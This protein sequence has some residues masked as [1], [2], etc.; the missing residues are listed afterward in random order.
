MENVCSSVKRSRKK[1]WRGGLT[2]KKFFGEEL[3]QEERE[4]RR[5]TKNQKNKGQKI[6]N[7]RGYEKDGEGRQ[8]GKQV[9]KEPSAP[10]MQPADVITEETLQSRN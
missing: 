2:F 4:E 1:F 5:N 9:D 10:H 8:G 3:S 7:V 6:L